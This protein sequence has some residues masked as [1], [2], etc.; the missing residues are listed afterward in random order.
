MRKNAR[1]FALFFSVAFRSETD[2]FAH[3]TYE[4]LSNNLRRA[5]GCISEKSPGVR[6]YVYI[7]RLKK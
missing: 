5:F 4:G 7:L 3:S 2:F 6:T 1:R